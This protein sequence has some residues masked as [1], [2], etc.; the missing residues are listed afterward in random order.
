MSND[1]MK[2]LFL[3]GVLKLNIKDAFAYDREVENMLE[4]H[5]QCSSCI[6]L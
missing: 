6:E 3:L 1:T 2:N 5:K 4:V